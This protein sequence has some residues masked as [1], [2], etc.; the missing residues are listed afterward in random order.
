MSAGAKSKHLEQGAATSRGRVSGRGAQAGPDILCLFQVGHDVSWPTDGLS[1]GP[2]RIFR[3]ELLFL[4]PD[5][6]LARLFLRFDLLDWASA[7]HG[8]ALG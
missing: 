2:C 8:R 1:G 7:Q 6:A 3:G 4:G 5:F